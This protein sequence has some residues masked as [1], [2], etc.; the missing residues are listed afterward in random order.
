MPTIP[1]PHTT[2]LGSRG[3]AILKSALEPSD[4]AL[5]RKDLTAAP[6]VPNSPIQPAKFPIYRESGTRI[7]VPRQYGIDEYGDPEI[8]RVPAGTPINVAF[9]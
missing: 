8:S 2:Y 4:L 5:I 6:H 7:Y 3:Y 9:T 1:N